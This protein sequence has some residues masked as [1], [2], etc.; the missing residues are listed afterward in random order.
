MAD[1]TTA[2]VQQK[3]AELDELESNI[4]NGVDLRSALGLK[5][6]R[7]DSGG[8]DAKYKTLGNR[9]AKEEF[10]KEW[11]RR[12]LAEKKTTVFKDITQ[13]RQWMETGTVGIEFIRN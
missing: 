12:W 5:F 2:A 9:L 10:R 7:S 3:S 13:E 8:K 1:P 4:Q 11:G 6:A